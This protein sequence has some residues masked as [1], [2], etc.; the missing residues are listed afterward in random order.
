MINPAEPFQLDFIVDTGQSGRNGEALEE[1]KI[2]LIKYFMA[3]LTVPEDDLWVNLSPFEQQRIIPEK[4]GLTDMGRDL[5]AQDYLLKQLTA[6]LMYPEEQLGQS[7]WDRVYQKAQEQYGTTDVPVNT[8]NKVWIV[9]EEA[10]IYEQGNAAF[11]VKTHLKVMLEE[12][13]IALDKN[14]AQ[15]TQA[16]GK[17]I[18]TDEDAVNSLASEVIREVILPAIEEEVNH[19]RNFAT[20]RQIYHSLILASWYKESIKQSLINQ[21]YS[22]QN[23]INGIDIDD[24]EAKERIY[25][26]YIAAFEEG[27]YDYIKE[28]L[29]PVTQEVIP[30]KYFSGGVRFRMGLQTGVIRRT[31]DSTGVN[32]VGDTEVT[33]VG[34]LRSNRRDQAVLATN[35][36]QLIFN[37]ESQDGLS[38]ALD[39]WFTRAERDGLKRDFDR[40]K[41]ERG[42]SLSGTSSL[43]ALRARDDGRVIGLASYRIGV[44][45]STEAEWFGQQI[46]F[47]DYIEVSPEFRGNGYSKVLFGEVIQ[48]SLEDPA[49]QAQP[50]TANP[51]ALVLNPAG[52]EEATIFGKLGF[53]ELPRDTSV[54]DYV[55]DSESLLW[56]QRFFYLSP[57]QASALWQ[58]AQVI[59]NQPEEAER[60]ARLTALYE[61]QAGAAQAGQQLDLFPDG[62]ND[63]SSDTDKAVL[64]GRDWQRFVPFGIQDNPPWLQDRDYQTFSQQFMGTNNVASMRMRTFSSFLSEA[65]IQL[66]ERFERG[67]VLGFGEGVTELALVKNAFNVNQLHGVEWVAERVRS[68]AQEMARAGAFLPNQYALHHAN[69]KNL[70]G[71]F[72]AGVFDFVYV[73]HISDDN[74][75]A[76]AI[77][78]KELVRILAPG[79]V[80][81]ID[82]G[83]PEFLSYLRANGQLT[84][85]LTTEKHFFQKAGPTAGVDETSQAGL[86]I[87]QTGLLR[88]LG[89]LGVISPELTSGIT[90]DQRLAELLAQSELFTDNALVKYSAG[91]RPTDS[92][93]LIGDAEVPGR[94]GGARLRTE[95]QY[96]FKALKQHAPEVVAYA[97]F[98]L[99]NPAYAGK[100]F[101]ALGRGADLIYDA[102]T[103][104]TYLDG[105]YASRREDITILDF[106]SEEISDLATPAYIEA[107]GEM[108]RRQ[109]G[110]QLGISTYEN[111]VF[112]NEVASEQ[113]A[114]Q[115]LLQTFIEAP[116]DYSAG[117]TYDNIEARSGTRY[118]GSRD[119]TAFDWLDTD[120][121]SGR[122]YDIQSF[123]VFGIGHAY[124]VEPFQRFLNQEALYAEVFRQ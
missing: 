62:V 32:A 122:R 97:R 76:S 113:N 16:L 67:I 121:R 7:F 101:V 96:Y 116:F 50:D 85:Y 34:L 110:R 5:L 81:L 72:G 3:S 26:Q 45:P 80:A 99:D 105:R 108:F 52:S 28:E 115:G 66:P 4:F 41:W 86:T 78:A 71:E 12:D 46:Y 91:Y 9:P 98:L 87:Q 104:L 109:L 2:R 93:D 107:Y 65:E 79:G 11:I 10:V 30:R 21:L 37:G 114:T 124:Q 49:W 90:R 19:G 6:T 1:E 47:V 112:V 51:G 40:S 60:N 102:L 24:R 61:A 92:I 100:K 119:T 118:D 33:R 29:D 15:R 14:L 13:Y 43:I 84:Q 82:E 58:E 95:N 23:K 42:R 8:F 74:Q 123:P 20:L 68:T 75:S 44:F 111:L 77:V 63:L 55:Y 57:S 83:N 18:N 25:R 48:A 53:R 39:E 35:T 94:V 31:A 73:A 59:R 22:D 89:A 27:V 38:E 56:A 120:Y 103:A 64:A 117:V 106:S 88:N 17:D 54:D 69:M 36:Q 70:S